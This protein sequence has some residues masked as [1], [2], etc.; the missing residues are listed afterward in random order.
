MVVRGTRLG[1]S[2]SGWLSFTA[3]LELLVEPKTDKQVGVSRAHL[4]T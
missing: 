3:G 1:P 2:N 4:Y